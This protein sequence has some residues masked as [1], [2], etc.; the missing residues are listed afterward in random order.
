[1]MNVNEFEK[2]Q[3]IFIF[4]NRGEK[5]SFSNDN[6]IVK[7]DEGNIKHQ[8]TCY[9][10]F[11]LYLIGHFTMTSGIIQRSHKFGFPIILMTNAL[12]VYDIIGNKMEGNFLLKQK[13]YTYNGYELAR[14]I[15]YKKISNQRWTLNQQRNKTDETKKVIA[16]IDEYKRSIRNHKGDL[17]GLLGLEG[18]TA[19][20]YFKTHF[21]N[22]EWL[23]RKPRIKSD[24]V[25][26][27]LDIGYTLLFSITESLLKIYG[28]DTYQGVLHQ[29]FFMRKSLVCDLIEPLRPL[30]DIE[31]KKAINLNQCKEEDFTKVNGRYLLD[32]RKNGEY[33]S[34]LMKPI[35][36]RK[37]DI[38]LYIQQYYRDFMKGKIEPEY[39]L[40]DMEK[41]NDSN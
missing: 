32:W 40:F 36:E 11:A 39:N 6:I 41:K 31:I 3:I 19:R 15:I 20:M 16:Q 2:K 34:F 1:M 37:R 27:T 5:L 4:L 21:N 26:S 10:L 24:Y 33:I 12:R 18:S 23:G 29:Q 8:S 9:R 25:N 35:L 7:D 22:I 17:Q 13:Q 28:F 14:E 30:I 38:F